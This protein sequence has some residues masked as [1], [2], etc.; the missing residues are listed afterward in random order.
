MTR[1]TNHRRTNIS[2][3]NT[4]Q[5]YGTRTNCNGVQSIT[6][7]ILMLT[8]TGLFT[9][10]TS[11][12]IQNT[13]QRQERTIARRR[14]EEAAVGKYLKR[15]RSEFRIWKKVISLKGLFYKQTCAYYCVF[16][17]EQLYRIYVVLLVFN[18]FNKDKNYYI[19]AEI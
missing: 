14:L 10:A 4:E 6:Q 15:F 11:Q 13:I 17:T 7:R 12:K 2:F 3:E 1:Y 18:A 5:R 19:N 16:D 9:G 8:F